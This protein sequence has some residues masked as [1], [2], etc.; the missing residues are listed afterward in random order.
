MRTEE[1][2]YLARDNVVALVLSS[3][4][5]AITHNQ[6]TRCQVVVGSVLLDSAVSPALF[7]LSNT[8]RLIL[9]FGASALLPGRYL[10]RLTVFDVSHTNGLVWGDFFL[11]VK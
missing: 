1:I 7:D 3:D 6:L 11:T 10:A 4:G 2:I 8:D 5:V 9:K